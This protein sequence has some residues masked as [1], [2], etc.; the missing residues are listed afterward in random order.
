MI[1]FADLDE[2]T[3]ASWVANQFGDE[4][5][6]EIYNAL[7]AQIAERISPTKSAGVPW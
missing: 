4:K 1:P 3:V 7:N 2:F 6:Q 5:I